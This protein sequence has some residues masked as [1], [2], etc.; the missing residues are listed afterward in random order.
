MCVCIIIICIHKHR[1]A[2]Y[3][4]YKMLII[5]K[6]MVYY[7]IICDKMNTSYFNTFINDLK[8]WLQN[9]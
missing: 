9:Y 7:I 8:L 2:W 6:K 3:S 5:V 1:Y 4:L